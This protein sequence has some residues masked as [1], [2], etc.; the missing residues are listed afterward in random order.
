MRIRS[1][2]FYFC[3]CTSKR[4]NFYPSRNRRPKKMENAYE[5]GIPSLYSSLKSSLKRLI[6]LMY[7][8]SKYA[9]RPKNL[10]KYERG[11][12]WWG[13][14]GFLMALRKNYVPILAREWKW[15][16]YRRK[17]K[18]IAV[19]FVNSLCIMSRY[20]SHLLSFLS[21]PLFKNGFRNPRQSRSRLPFGI[22]CTLVTSASQDFTHR[23]TC[24]GCDMDKMEYSACYDPLE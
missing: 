21:F 16:S 6:F 5:K 20:T 2:R 7:A 22:L 14:A 3:D 9:M 12:I 19:K 11:S 13:T 10:Q 4:L 1:R 15:H 17:R 18:R 8:F 23:W 24:F